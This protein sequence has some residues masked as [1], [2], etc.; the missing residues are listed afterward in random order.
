MQYEIKTHC[1]II[2]ADTKHLLRASFPH[3]TKGTFR[4]SHFLSVVFDGLSCSQVR[5]QLMTKH[6]DELLKLAQINLAST[7]IDAIDK[8]DPMWMDLKEHDWAIVGSVIEL[9]IT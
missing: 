5:D 9:I 7:I 2:D 1:R 3:N 8:N 6:E 4:S